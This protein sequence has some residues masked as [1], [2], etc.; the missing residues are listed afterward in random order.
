MFVYIIYSGIPVGSLKV[1]T[2]KNYELSLCKRIKLDFFFKI[3]LRLLKFCTTKI[4]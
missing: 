2:E 4:Q 3:N 1:Y